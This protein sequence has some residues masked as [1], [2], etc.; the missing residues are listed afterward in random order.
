MS[1]VYIFQ[2]DAEMVTMTEN[3][4]FPLKILLIY[5]IMMV[6]LRYLKGFKVMIFYGLFIRFKGFLWAKRALN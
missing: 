3:P 4:I 2:Q 5:S 6:S 1:T